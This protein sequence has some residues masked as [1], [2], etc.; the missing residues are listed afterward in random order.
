MSKVK[1][2]VIG[3]G[4]F[5]EYHADVASSMAQ[6]ELVGVCTRRQERLDQVAT[7][8]DVPKKFTD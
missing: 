4:F 7:Q 1:H 6:M 8:F 2:G 3:L 5:G